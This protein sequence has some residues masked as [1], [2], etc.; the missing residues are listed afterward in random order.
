MAEVSGSG[1]VY[2]LNGRVQVVFHDNPHAASSFGSLNGEVRVSFPSS[3][4]ADLRFKT[5]NG[6]VYT[7][8]PVSYLP[9]KT[10]AGER[11]DGKFVYKSNEWSSVRVGRGGPELS[12]DAFNGNIRILS[13]EQ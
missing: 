3:L 12:F 6:G 11:H 1:R 7:D 8:F 10:A 9:L 2:A 5:F 13:R 4:A